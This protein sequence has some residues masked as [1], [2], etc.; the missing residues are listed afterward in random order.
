MVF[1]VQ[2]IGNSALFCILLNIEIEYIASCFGGDITMNANF[3][4]KIYASNLPE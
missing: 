4:V 2:T 3:L 1:I